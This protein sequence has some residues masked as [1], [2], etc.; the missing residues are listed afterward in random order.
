VRLIYDEA[1]RGPAV[2]LLHAGIGDRT[3]WRE[4]LEPLAAAGY[5]VIAPDLPG[6]G[7]SPVAPGEQAPW[8]DVLETMAGLGLD[9]AALVGNSFGGAVALRAALVAPVAVSALALISA[10]APGLEPSAELEAVW[11]A[12][13]TALERGDVDGAVRSV[14]DAWTLPDAPADLRERVAVM[15]RRALA[16]QANAEAVDAASDPLEEEPARLAEI[17]VPTLVAVG[18][19]EQFADFPE[20]AQ[21]IA[22]AIPRARHAVI[23]G[24]G[25]LAPLEAPEAFRE[26][27][28]GFLAGV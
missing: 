11:E 13:E 28:L 19:R 21:A 26:L 25:H 10:P 9:R 3:M 2:V 20:G 5:R 7:E 12:E 23:A 6:F 15:E 16:L 4:H 24:A 22:A 17:K 18:E 14:L 8:N 1:G 27:L